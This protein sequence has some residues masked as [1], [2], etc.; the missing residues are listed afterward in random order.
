VKYRQRGSKW[1]VFD[2]DRLVATMPVFGGGE[3]DHA[4]AWAAIRGVL[5]EMAEAMREARKRANSLRYRDINPGEREKQ[6]TAL[7]R[8]LED[9]LREDRARL[10]RIVETEIEEANRPQKI[11]GSGVDW[12]ELSARRD[13]VVL[14]LGNASGSN[15]GRIV[16][17][18]LSDAPE[19]YRPAL[20]RAAAD[21]VAEKN[22]PDARRSFASTRAKFFTEPEA[23]HI[24]RRAAAEQLR[25]ALTWLD[26]SL[27]REAHRA[28]AAT[29]DGTHNPDRYLGLWAKSWQDKGV[30]AGVAAV[31]RVQAGSDLAART[32]AVPARAGTGDDK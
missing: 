31:E 4:Q 26:Q 5:D 12:A 28:T 18:E 9:V 29:N 14:R 3:H 17:E 7:R 1:L 2:G 11:T 32:N 20:V 25:S 19:Q 27:P 13:G 21:V 10:G 22:D 8:E 16:E 23:L 30:A 15:V 24:G 6:L